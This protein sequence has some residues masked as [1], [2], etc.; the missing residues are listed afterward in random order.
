MKQ[1]AQLLRGHPQL[2]QGAPVADKMK[3]SKLF[4]A[5]RARDE[6]DSVKGQPAGDSPEIRE[7]APDTSRKLVPDR[8]E[9]ARRLSRFPSAQRP[10]LE[11]IFVLCD[12]LLHIYIYREREREI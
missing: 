11:V 2:G 12:W 9:T 3:P 8:P 1:T 7:T 6:C 10:K 4:G 5:A